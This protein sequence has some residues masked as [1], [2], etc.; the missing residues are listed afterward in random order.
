MIVKN[1]KEAR[2]IQNVAA[3]MAVENMP[4]SRTFT[5]ELV[6]V[7]NGEKTSM[8]LRQEVIQ[9]YTKQP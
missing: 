7:A 2:S 3:T 1:T 4:L 8:Q 5:E 6:K 9:K